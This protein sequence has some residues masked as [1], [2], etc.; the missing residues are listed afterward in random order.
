MLSHENQL[1]LL[2]IHS[3]PFGIYMTEQQIYK[4]RRAFYR[5]VK[6]LE[7]SG[8]IEKIHIPVMNKTRICLTAKGKMLAFLIEPLGVE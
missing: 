7:E 3:Q 6:Y 4:H 8:F 2:Q 5:A 1:L